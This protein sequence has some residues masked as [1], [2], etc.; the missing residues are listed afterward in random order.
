MLAF[1]L[2]CLH[3]I[4]LKW[5]PTGIFLDPIKFYLV[6]CRCLSAEAEQIQ[7]C[8]K[9]PLYGFGNIQTWRRG[10]WR[11]WSIRSNSRLLYWAWRSWA[12]SKV[13]WQ[14]HF[15]VGNRLTYSV[16][17]LGDWFYAK[18]SSSR[19]HAWVWGWILLICTLPADLSTFFVRIWACFVCSFVSRIE[20][21][22]QVL[23][24]CCKSLHSI[25]SQPSFTCKHEK[26]NNPIRAAHCGWSCSKVS[27]AMV[28]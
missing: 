1:L 4:I 12:S 17:H 28:D 2:L 25:R 20:S 16:F 9:I 23:N 13:L 14:I 24:A 6:S 3:Y 5:L 21:S 19:G 7:G 11:H 8:N 15:K 18:S 27:H 10:F 22:A 26:S